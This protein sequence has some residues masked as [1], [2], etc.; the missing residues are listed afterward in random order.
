MLVYVCVVCAVGLCRLTHRNSQP[1]SVRNDKNLKHLEQEVFDPDHPVTRIITAVATS[2]SGE[3]DCGPQLAVCSG[4]SRTRRRTQDDYHERVLG[5]ISYFARSLLSV[6]RVAIGKVH[7][8][9][10]TH[11]TIIKIMDIG[12]LWRSEVEL[13]NSG[14]RLSLFPSQTTTTLL[15]VH[16]SRKVQ[17]HA[18]LPT[19]RLFRYLWG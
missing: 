13:A 7:K 11:Q 18:V 5:Y 10:T 17:L 16:C 4:C 2:T 15:Q 1:L 12:Y 6:G 3:S 14:K 19:A 9:P 8:K